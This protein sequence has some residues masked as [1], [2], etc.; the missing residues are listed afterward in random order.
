MIYLLHKKQSSNISSHLI[1]DSTISKKKEHL[2]IAKAKAFL[3]KKQIHKH[4]SKSP[5]TMTVCVE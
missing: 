3:I 4:L 5:Y 1:D 2:E